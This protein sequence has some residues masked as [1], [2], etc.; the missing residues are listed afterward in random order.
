M[1][2]KKP[3]GCLAPILLYIAIFLVGFF[4]YEQMHTQAMASENV[5][6][7]ELNAHQTFRWFFWG[8]IPVSIIFYIVRLNA[9]SQ[10]YREDIIAKTDWN[11]CNRRIAEIVANI[12]KVSYV[13]VHDADHHQTLAEVLGDLRL[14]S[15]SYGW[16]LET[17]ILVEDRF[18]ES[19]GIDYTDKYGGSLYLNY[20]YP[21]YES[22]TL[23]ILDSNSGMTLYKSGHGIWY[24]YLGISQE[25]NLN[26]IKSHL[27]KSNP[28]ISKILPK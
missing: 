10:R 4:I 27:N 17:G 28:Y 18:A 22:D 21:R 24:F 23:K 8:G 13:K 2:N 6:Q 20:P 5:L 19:Y 1:D 3:T 12:E 11:S 9:W 14:V 15:T 26:I 16:R 7:G 25:I